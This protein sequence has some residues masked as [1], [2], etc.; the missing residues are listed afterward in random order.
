M[1]IQRVCYLENQSVLLKHDYAVRVM[2]IVLKGNCT[3]Q[4]LSPNSIL[5]VKL[6][7]SSNI[8]ISSDSDFAMVQ[9][10]K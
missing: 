3:E 4:E 10:K 6:L 8:I 9:R 1:N 2:L 5:N 7:F